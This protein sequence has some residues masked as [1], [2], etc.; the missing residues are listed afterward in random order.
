MTKSKNIKTADSFNCDA[1]RFE[2]KL[3]GYLIDL[4]LNH[5]VSDSIA[6]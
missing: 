3:K 1:I 2:G 4:F 6:K 5:Q